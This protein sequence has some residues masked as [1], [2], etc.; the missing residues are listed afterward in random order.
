[1]K[2]YF[3]ALI[4]ILT[5]GAMAG[6]SD[7]KATSAG[8]ISI[9]VTPGHA[10]NTLNPLR[11]LGAGVD[12]LP[13]GAVAKVYTP[14]NLSEMLASGHGALSYRLFTELSVQ[15]WHWNSAGTWSDPAQR[16]YFVGSATQFDPN[17]VTSFGYDLPHRGNTVDQGAQD[18]FSKLTDG[19]A[20]TYWKSNPY[21]ATAFTGE[22]DALHPQWVIVDLGRPENINAV[23]I[24]W[25]NPYAVE[26]TV[27]YWEG[28]SPIDSP[29]DGSWKTFSNGVVHNATG[30]SVTLTVADAPMTVRFV[31]VLM[32]QSSG[33]F[34]THGNSDPRNAMGYAIFEIGIGLNNGGTFSDLCRHGAGQNQQSVTYASSVDPWHDPSAKNTNQE[35]PGVDQV[36]ASGLTRGLP[37]MIPVALLY[38]TPDDAAAEVQYLIARGYSISYIEMGEEPDGQ[39]IAPEDYGALY[40]QFAHAIHAVAPTIKLGGPAFQSG[41]A[42]QFWPDSNGETSWFKRFLNYLKAHG[43]LNDLAFFSFEH[44]P[45]SSSETKGTKAFATLLQTPARIASVITNFRND[46]LPPN[47]PIY[48]TEYNFCADNTP[49]FQDITGALWQADF[50]GSFLALGGSGANYYEYEPTPYS[51]SADR[52]SALGS[53]GMFYADENYAVVART[54]QFYAAQL[55]MTE[56][57]TQT[58]ANHAILPVHSTVL[59]KKGNTFV[60]AYAVSRPDGQCAVMFINKSANKD[61]TVNVNFQNAADGSMPTLTGALTQV[62]FGANQFRWHAR[63]RNS[64]AHPNNPPQTTS[65]DLMPANLTLPKASIT[66]LRGVL[67]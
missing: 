52:F 49:A 39:Y 64:F 24:D 40:L 27:E 19:D 2:Y 9:D 59:D 20:A 48:V 5:L 32:T 50:M 53:L 44:Y 30:G 18:G 26:Y 1:M 17:P 54:A 8:S 65:L 42:I 46:G 33:T 38:S 6:E 55:I 7:M 22:D 63:K 58:D 66:V 3:I 13:G 62:T 56:W 45:F 16:G 43:R 21:L 36:F 37:T 4:A 10:L 15:A 11:T 47:V 35:Q 23:H 31:R 34:D 25:A 60:T 29:A 61:A 14:K 57:L 51:V 28:D 41:D 12:A 67:K